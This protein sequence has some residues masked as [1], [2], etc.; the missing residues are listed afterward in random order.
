MGEGL[1]RMP[2]IQRTVRRRWWDP[3]GLWTSQLEF[4][5]ECSG[6]GDEDSSGPSWRQ[7]PREQAGLSRKAAERSHQ[8]GWGGRTPAP[9]S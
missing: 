1:E 9:T 7:R 8:Q 6:L 5:V 2:G 4:S 3:D